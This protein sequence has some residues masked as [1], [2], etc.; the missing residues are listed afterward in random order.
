MNYC[1]IRNVK[2][3][4]RATERSA[5][6]DLYVPFFEK[7]FVL[8]AHSDLLVPTGIK[9]SIPRGYMLM[10]ADRSGVAAS[11]IARAAVGLPSKPGALPCSVIVGACI[12]DEDYQGEILV[13]LINTGTSVV[14]I[15]PG[16]KIAQAILIP[17]SYEGLNEVPKKEL[18]A[19]KT[20]RAEG[21]FGSSDI[22]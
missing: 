13:H 6:I 3:P 17:V 20:E 10:I 16:M 18:F 1:K 2:S 15:S 12:V 5:G 9:I 11:R 14:K 8:D 19:E 7:E 22:Y 4:E 21:G